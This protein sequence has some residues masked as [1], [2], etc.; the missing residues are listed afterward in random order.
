MSRAYR[1]RSDVIVEFKNDIT[2]KQV[3]NILGISETHIS[4]VLNRKK[5]ASKLLA[6]SI[7]LLNRYG[8]LDYF[9]EEVED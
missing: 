9:F 7:S 6:T 2:Q 4:L 5:N 3:S 1:L 8:N